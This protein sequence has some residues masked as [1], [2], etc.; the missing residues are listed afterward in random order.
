MLARLHSAN[1]P[2]LFDATRKRMPRRRQQS[3]VRALNRIMATAAEGYPSAG[4]RLL[5][6]RDIFAVFMSPDEYK[7]IAE[8]GRAIGQV[9]GEN[10]F[11][12][13]EMLMLAGRRWRIVEVDSERRELSVRPAR[14]GNPPVFGGDLRP[15]SDGVVK[16]MRRVWEDLAFPAYLD[17]TAKQLLVEARTT[18]DR[19]GLRSASI[20]RHEGQLLLFPWVGQRRQQALILA[21]ARDELEPAQLGVAVAVSADKES[22]LVETLTGLAGRAPPDALELAE[23]VEN[24]EMEKFDPFLGEELLTIAWARDRIDVEG[25]PD[26]A[27]RLLAG[28]PV[29]QR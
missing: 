3:T 28:F 15:P 25:L 2:V 10:P 13:G 4:E 14:G 8:G 6:S 27:L 18:Y 26:M 23:L 11:T 19:V 1:L 5:E 29:V 24:K 20:A 21:L 9:P 17:E 22:A 12:P 16:E 7:V